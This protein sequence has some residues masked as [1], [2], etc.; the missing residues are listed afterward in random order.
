VVVEDGVDEG[1]A[2]EWMAEVLVPAAGAVRGGDPVLQTLG[3]TQVA[4]ASTIGDIAELLDINVNQGPGIVVLVA[5]DRF[6]GGPVDVGEPVEAT[7]DQDLV[8][9]RRREPD[10][11][12][13][14]DRSQTMLPTQV[15]DLADHGL[16]RLVGRVARL[17]GGIAH[18]GLAKV[19]IPLRPSFRGRP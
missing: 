18:A 6:A 10:P 7:P 16:G 11:V 17:G 13:D 12:G 2:D 15:H 8:H 1:C 19:A 4:P 9:G 5:A 14:L 3:T